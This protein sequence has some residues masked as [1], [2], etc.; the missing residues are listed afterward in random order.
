M[1]LIVISSP[2]PIEQEH[3]IVNA[4]FKSGMEY[5]H[6]RKP[7]C[8]FEEMEAYI[9]QVDF[10][11]RNRIIIHTHHQLAI[12]YQLK[13]I[14]YS[15]NSVNEAVALPENIQQSVALHR[16]EELERIDPRFEYAFLSPVFDSI[17]KKD[18][19]AKFEKEELF[20]A[21]ENCDSDTEIIAL[22]GIDEDR[23][24]E[25]LELGFDGVATLGA[26]WQEENPVK[27][28]VALNGIIE[29]VIELNNLFNEE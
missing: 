21:L 29:A 7:T 18:Y 2:T 15:S 1:K 6:L 22:G 16:L 13:G 20:N 28:F 26:I 25:A 10:D 17:S 14:H 9:K 3:A 5:F 24:Y 4:M 27:K 19:P 11:F 23:V 8:S 12:D